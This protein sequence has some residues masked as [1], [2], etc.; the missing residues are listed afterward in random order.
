M[1]VPNH[2]FPIATAYNLWPALPLLF[3]PQA[4]K[5]ARTSPPLEAEWGLEAD[6]NTRLLSVSA[7]DPSSSFNN[8]YHFKIIVEHI[9]P[10]R[11]KKR[12]LLE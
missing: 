4:K 6:E 2:K 3:S 8:S 5:E 7:Q 12:E 9:S 11:K 10:A 1:N